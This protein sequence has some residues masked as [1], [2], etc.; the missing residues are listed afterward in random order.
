[1][2]ANNLP[3]M[4]SAS[5]QVWRL[6]EIIAFAKKIHS[7]LDLDEVL[8]QFLD[9]A[10]LELSADSA[11]LYLVNQEGNEFVLQER[12]GTAA[13]DDSTRLWAYYV[14]EKLEN[15][16]GGSVSHQASA[17]RVAAP[18]IRDGNPYRTDSSVAFPVL[19]EN[20]HMIG[21]FQLSREKSKPFETEDMVFLKQI[22][23][24]AGL[25][26]KNAQYHKESLARAR[27][28]REI[29]LARQIQSRLV[30]RD[31]P[32]IHGFEAT[33][34]LE[35]CHEMAGD[36][37][38]FFCSGPKDFV[39]LMDVSGK[40]VAAAMVASA[41]H[42]FL[43]VQLPISECLASQAEALNRFL[44]DTWH[45]DKYATGVIVSI[46]N[47]GCVSY[48][49][50]GHPPI[51]RFA[52]RGVEHYESTG[53]PLGMMRDATYE[54]APVMSSPGDL[55]CIYS[56][57]YTEASDEQGSMIGI[58]GLARSI[59]AVWRQ[60][61]TDV[62]ECVNRDVCAHQGGAPE[63]DDKTMILLRRADGP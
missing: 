58:A 29:E 57:G 44:Y 59:G 45:G 7:S 3:N 41:I 15:E 60:E 31:A 28:A 47:D 26:I 30:P 52:D 55:L 40:G 6:S 49:S 13:C 33:S 32:I 51:L 8:T 36:Y 37:C 53:F 34:F 21:A 39:V 12:L 10:Q 54:S 42:T 19:D 27:V 43:S 48:V 5:D 4:A 25:A 23:H 22:C 20:G 50:A 11:A 24:F 63:Q 38:Q 56:D 61:L 62:L 46:A 9:V 18:R 1:M 16:K 35:P 17:A 2:A 14:A